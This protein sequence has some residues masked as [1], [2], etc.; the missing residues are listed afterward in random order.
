MSETRYVTVGEA[1]ERFGRT[2]A[3]FQKAA[4]RGT[5]RTIKPGREYLCTI[6]DAAD[7]VASTAARG[8][9][10]APKR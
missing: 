9:A 7:Y 5:L 2:R 4:F 1:A 10:R 6:E 3:A 8:Y